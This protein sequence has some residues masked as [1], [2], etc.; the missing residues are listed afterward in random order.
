MAVTH[1]VA[2]PTPVDECP[3]PNDLYPIPA[4]RSVA[5]RSEDL[6][7]YQ[8]HLTAA[9][10]QRACV[11]TT[12]SLGADPAA[13]AGAMRELLDNVV[14]TWWFVSNEQDAG[15]LT[16]EQGNRVES[17]A[18]DRMDPPVYAQFWDAVVPQI[19]ARQPGVPVA[20]GGFVSG[21]VDVL[22]D[23]ERFIR[24]A[25]YTNLHPWNKDATQAMGFIRDCRQAFG[26]RTRFIIGEWNRPADQIRDYV[27]MLDQQQVHAAFFFSWH[28]F[29]VDALHDEQGR[30][31]ALY[32]AFI[33]ALSASQP[34][35]VT[36]TQRIEELATMLGPEKL[37]NG[38][39][40]NGPLLDFG[41]GVVAQAYWNCVIYDY[42]EEIGAYAHAQAHVAAELA[43]NS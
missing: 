9:G 34:K 29:D 39:L 6:Y 43:K 19:R 14:P 24:E 15:Y 28:R 8:D 35:E 25:D 30:P 22:R 21:S 11:V 27:R 12:E 33:E 3:S 32:H 23:Y 17:T 31:T 38:G 10:I 40:K 41:N 4:V 42:G 2:I 1:G 20:T 37:G 18:S 5:L 7:R 36:V 26:S 13:W 16:D